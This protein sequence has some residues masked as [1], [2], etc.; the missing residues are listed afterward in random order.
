VVGVV[1]DVVVEVEVGAEAKTVAQIHWLV[2][3]GGLFRCMLC[4]EP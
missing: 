1:L 3:K 2:T 4:A